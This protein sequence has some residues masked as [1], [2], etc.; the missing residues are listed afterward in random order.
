MHF[1]D[2]IPQWPLVFNE[3]VDNL[4]RLGVLRPKVFVLVGIWENLRRT[5]QWKATTDLE[6]T[7]FPGSSE[8]KNPAAIQEP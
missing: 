7:G 2:G 6:S 8:V 4:Q 3:K 1:C 5:W